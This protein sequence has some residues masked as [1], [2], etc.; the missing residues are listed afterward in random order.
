MSE[1]ATA[2]DF[3]PVWTRRVICNKGDHDAWDIRACRVAQ[4]LNQ[5]KADEFYASTPPLEAK[6]LLL[7]QMATE[8]I[9]KE[10][11]DPLEMSFVDI[12]KAYFN[13]IPRRRLH[14]MFHL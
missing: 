11:G 12:R 13:A 6:R 14:I 1:A 7:S 5:Y 3:K 2:P 4:E 10:T 9:D 8:R